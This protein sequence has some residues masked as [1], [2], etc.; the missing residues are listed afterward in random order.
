MEREPLVS[1][2]TV[3]FNGEKFLKQTI[4]SVVNQTYKNIE[5]IIID[6]GSTDNTL[7]IIEAH[8]NH[9]SC[10][11][12]EPDK[13]LYDAMNKGIRKAKGEL[14]GMI[15]SD[16]WYELNAVEDVVRAYLENPE[17]TIIHGD[18]YDVKENGD[19]AVRKF[20]GSRFKLLY[21]GMTYNHPSMFV[22][23][24]I[25]SNQS[26]NTD[27]KSLSDFEF[28]LKN[29]MQDNNRFLYLNSC[30]VNYRLDGLSGQMSFTK[31]LKEGLRVRNNCNFTILQKF[32]Y[33]MVKITVHLVSRFKA[34][35]LKK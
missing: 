3:V 33:I 32:Q 30:Y 25:Y 34:F 5:Y 17:K 4:D 22:H 7:K 23:S 15:N 18:R 35:L 9:F 26:Y 14:V 8:K 10:I 24:S 29:F 6:G 28:V 31:D 13:G 19:K 21:Y 12:S 11:V 2:I 1:I 20:N 27:L 16:D